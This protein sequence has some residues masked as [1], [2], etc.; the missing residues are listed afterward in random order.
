M[1]LFYKNKILISGIFPLKNYKIDGYIEKTGIF[2]EKMIN[3]NEPEHIFYS[4]GHLIN[5]CYQCVGKKEV[6]YEFFESEELVEY[7]VNDELNKDEIHMIFLEEQTNK[8][9]LLQE[10]IRLL[11]GLAITL[12]V[13]L[14]T[15]YKDD[16]FYT[17]VGNVTWTTTNLKVHD[18]DDDMKQKLQN[19]LNFHM[20]NSTIIELK[21][22]N[23][24]Y[25]RALN[26]YNNSFNSS[27]RGV[28]FTLLFSS[29]EA[30]FN[31]TAE[32][33]T[34]EV[35]KYASK[36]LFLNKNKAK[37][38]KW[39][40]I[41]YYDIRSK[42]IHGNDGFEITK[43]IEH[44]LREY[45]R[46]ILL[47][48]WCISMTY[49]ITDA[50]EIK[51]LLDRIDNDTIDMKVQLFVKYLRTDTDKFGLLYDKIRDNFL[52]GNYHVLSSE[53]YTI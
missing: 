13:F 18:Y 4:A 11:T 33:I 12:P 26:F 51:N 36:I 8:I 15:I 43:K 14:T 21:E 47:I 45:V 6:N 38:S 49:N 24:R 16:V 28:R 40:I 9:D 10:K 29:L 2:D 53:D 48:Y 5:S 17:C 3:V 37:S 46:E 1:K 50:Q 42:Y 19:R 52:N 32:N 30:L 20:S 39:K 35:S 25:E 23:S 7:E 41:N 34:D 22:K 31:I 27:D 44:N